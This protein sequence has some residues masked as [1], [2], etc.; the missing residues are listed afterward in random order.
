M[1]LP[2]Q[3]ARFVANSRMNVQRAAAGLARRDRYLAAVFPQHA[4]RRFVQTRE[5]DV[6]DASAEKRHAIPRSPSAGSVLP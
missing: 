6:R 2:R 5:A 1:L 4:H 3:L